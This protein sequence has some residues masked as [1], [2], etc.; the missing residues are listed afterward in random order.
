E[1]AGLPVTANV[2]AGDDHMAV[3]RYMLPEE[4]GDV[5]GVPAADDDLDRGPVQ[6]G[7]EDQGGGA[8]PGV[9][10]GIHALILGRSRGPGVTLHPPTAGRRLTPWPAARPGRSG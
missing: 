1:A 2:D 7:L 9:R 10:D 3:E 8:G 6:D 5:R 4:H